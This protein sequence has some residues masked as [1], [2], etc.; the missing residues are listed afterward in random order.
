LVLGPIIDRTGLINALVILTAFAGVAIT[1]GVL[2][3]A[4]GAPLLVVAA[5]GVSPVFPTMMAVIAKLFTDEID[6]AMTAVTTVMGIIMVPAN[7]MVGGIINLARPV[8]TRIYGEVGVRIAYSA[9]YMFL[10]LCVLGAF[11]FT[12][13]LR[14]RL[15]KSGTL[16]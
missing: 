16:V 15:K 7:L 2:L 4:A 13:L 9:G 8:L 6:L 14:R 1:A 10:G 12:L 3:G 5:I 11:A